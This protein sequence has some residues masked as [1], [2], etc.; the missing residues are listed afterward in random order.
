[1]ALSE[2]ELDLLAAEDFK[3]RRITNTLYCN[4]C[5]YNLKTL[6]YK[7]LCPECGNSYDVHPS[8]MTGIYRYEHC[9]LPLF[10]MLSTLFFLVA[11]LCFIPFAI[12]PIQPV[13][14]IF[15]VF[16]DVMMILYAFRTYR[17]FIL[18]LRSRSIAR[19]IASEE[20]FDHEDE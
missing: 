5:G 2:K 9:H 12:N 8:R 19:H 6:P 17:K 14:L 4:K 15:T 16:L 3:G 11:C 10:D 7:Y 1:M 13:M 18:Y 20:A